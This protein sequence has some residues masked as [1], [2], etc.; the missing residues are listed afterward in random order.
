MSTPPR[1]DLPAGRA[2][3]LL[4]CE[5]TS[6]YCG[7]T[8]NLTRRL[9]HHASGKGSGYTKGVRPVALVWFEPAADRMQAAARERQIKKWNHRKKQDLQE[10]LIL[11]SD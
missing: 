2:C 8:S 5:D 9:Q 1:P 4:L 7:L 3:Y 6:F 10:G 11:L